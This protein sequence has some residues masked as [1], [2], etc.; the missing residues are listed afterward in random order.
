MQTGYKELK[1]KSDFNTRF[2]GRP[3][4]LSMKLQIIFG[5]VLMIIG[6]IFGGMGLIVFIVF[7]SLVDFSSYKFDGNSPV[8]KGKILNVNPTNSFVNDIQV[9]EYQYEYYLTSGETF[10]GE[11]FTTGDLFFKDQEVVVQ[12]L[13]SDPKMSKLEGGRLGAFDT[14]ILFVIM[15]FMLIGGSMFGLRLAF[16]LKAIKLL[17]FGE[18][19]FG[20]LI[21]KQLTN[22]KI[23]NS[24]VYK[25][26]FEFTALDGL[27]YQAIAKTHIPYTLEDETEEK[28]VY[29]ANNPQKAV[30]IDSLPKIVKKFFQDVK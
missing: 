13:E 8:T 16:G 15:P 9:F 4:S 28:L 20:K 5:N 24:P 18:V 3:I 25:L 27:T 14:W 22:T 23:N 17:R 19:G 1:R 11:S 29:D 21:D 26:I 30:L 6:I 10:T 7:G 2:E 12:Y